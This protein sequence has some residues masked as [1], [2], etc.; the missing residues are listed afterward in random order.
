[1]K[2]LIL[3]LILAANAHGG[4]F[5]SGEKA[6]RDRRIAAEQQLEQERR[7]SGGLVIVASGLAIGCVILFTIGAALGSKT[8]R[9]ANKS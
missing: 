4:W 7:A 3:L 1:M 8:R 2:K 6:E 5:D 9:D